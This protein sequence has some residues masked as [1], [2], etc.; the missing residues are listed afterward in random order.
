MEYLYVL[1]LEPSPMPTLTL[2]AAC[3]A[4]AKAC[5]VSE[6]DQWHHNA[7]VD[8]RLSLLSVLK[9]MM[10]YP[11]INSIKDDASLPILVAVDL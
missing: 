5:G 10:A 8:G 1:S 2:I 7:G 6:C 9:M 11:G 3:L 4:L